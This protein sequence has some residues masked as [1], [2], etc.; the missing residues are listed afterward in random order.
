MINKTIRTIHKLRIF[1]FFFI[2]ISF[3]SILGADPISVS[4]FLGAKMGRAVGISVTA[5]VPPNPFNTLALQL[6]EKEERLAQKEVELN[7]REEE[8]SRVSNLQT[9]LIWGMFAGIIVLF[10]LILLNYYLDYQ[11]RK[12]E[13]NF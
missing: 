13:K 4:K 6:K 7:K 11:R 10:L 3:L 5:G 1:F 2:L 12:N 9:K 8:L